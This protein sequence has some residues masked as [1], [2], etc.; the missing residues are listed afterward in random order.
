ML[1]AV[2]DIK[3]KSLHENVSFDEKKQTLFGR[4]SATYLQ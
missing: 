1:I 2:T 3:T 4:L